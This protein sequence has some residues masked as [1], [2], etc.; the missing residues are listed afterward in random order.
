VYVDGFY[1]GTVADSSRSPDGLNLTI[2]WHRLV[3]RAPGY[4]TP[5]VNVTILPNQTPSYRGELKSLDR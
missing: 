2:G 1:S 3:F 5:A 4:E